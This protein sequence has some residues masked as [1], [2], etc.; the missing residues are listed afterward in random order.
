MDV[1]VTLLDRMKKENR[2]IGQSFN[3]KYYPLVFELAMKALI[4]KTSW[5]DLTYH[6]GDAIS[7]IF[8]KPGQTFSNVYKI[9]DY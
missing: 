1:T 7:A 3:K 9:F 5:L 4:T 8:G 6:E 2:D